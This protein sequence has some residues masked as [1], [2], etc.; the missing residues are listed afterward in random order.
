MTRLIGPANPFIRTEVDAA[1]GADLSDPA[2]SWDWTTLGD[3]Q[4]GEHTR[5]RVLNQTI[6]VAHGRRDESNVADP[7][8]IEVE[9]GNGDGALTPRNPA[10]SLYPGLVRGTP[11]RVMV[12]AGS[13]YLALTGATGS[14][15]TTPDAGSWN[16]G[17]NAAWAVQFRAPLRYPMLG[18]VY[19][20][21]GQFTVSG[22]QRSWVL[23][24]DAA[25]FGRLRF[26]SNGTAEGNATTSLALPSPDAGPLTFAAEFDGDNGAG[27]NTTTFYVCRGTITEL[28]ADPAGF[29]FGDPFVN[30][31]TV[32]L[33]NSTGLIGVGDVPGSGF[34]PYPG[35]IAA[36]Y[37]RAGTLTSGTVVA[38]TR[39]LPSQA[40]GTTSF[41]DQAATP[42]TWTVNSS[43]VITNRHPRFTGRVDKVTAKWEQVDG[44][45]PLMPTIA[46]AHV[47]ASGVLERLAQGDSIG[48]ALARLVSAPVNQSGVIAAWMFEDGRD[49]TQAAQLVSG[50][51]PMRIRG[52]FSFGGDTSY[53]AVLQQ[54]TIGS[55]ENAYMSAP[56]PQIP[57][58]V[59]VNWQ[60]TRFFRI[61]DP[62]VAP[63]TTQLMAVDT[64]G[65]VATWRI[66][67]N[68]T[69]IV[70]TGVDID[71]TPILLDTLA[72]D[73]TWFDTEA[74]VVLEVTDN[75]ANVDWAVTMLP[76]PFG[77]GFTVSGSLAGNTGVPR[78]FRNSCT[79]P[80]SGISLGPLI[81][82]TGK[83]IG[84][85]AP[86]DTAF[87]G[88]PAPQRVFRLCQ[89]QGIP[90]AVDGPYGTDWA[91]GV[92]AGAQTMGPQRP[93]KLVGLLE[94]CATVDFGALGEQRGSLGLAFR[95]GVSL[96]NQ[97]TRLSLARADRQAIDPFEEVDDDQRFVND[98]TA[99]RPEGS[100]FRIEDPRIAAGAEER[101][102]QT[103]EVNT[104]T[105]LGLED[106]AGWRYHL[107]TWEEPRFPQAWSDV[108]KD[109]A[110]VDDILGFG[111]GDR[112]DLADPPPGCPPVDQLAD[113]IVEELERFQWRVGL[114]GHP[115]R[116]WD[117]GIL[118]HDERSQPDT[119]GAELAS[120]FV[121]GTGT[122]M[123][124][125]TTEGDLW[126]TTAGDF[127]FHVEVAGVVLNVTN[128][129][130]ASSPQ[131]F[132]VTQA[133]VN[134]VAKTIPVGEPVRLRHGA[135]VAP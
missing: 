42:K 48:S 123:S 20:F 56:I 86:A 84:W 22:G 12:T 51:A 41:V 74:M 70:I 103:V 34:A 126:T 122:S 125:A 77:G 94:E 95:S 59:G 27:G 117:T 46:Y 52:D 135:I 2:E 101:Y 50:A 111:I 30:S 5:P 127:P 99:T 49:A 1:F 80:P 7:S 114:N 96:Q 98:V 32:T 71:D 76:I 130:G 73:P 118:E 14:N 100:S 53:P 120:Q 33:H 29:L 13:S 10:S 8:S 133:P 43:A 124:V 3:Y 113:G 6:A 9:L 112:F 102:E 66:A 104:A 132:T 88:E 18:L 91:Q 47:S 63:A 28:L 31:G 62:A 109:Q 37:V 121:A 79:G 35:T 24:A 19:E 21:F 23:S 40:A 45:N 97:P 64:N 87:V 55:G 58:V 90:V 38:D 54:L 60:V 105:D 39:N 15:V 4:D 93:E 131:T 92:A 78:M 67:I 69:Q 26:S 81:V 107:G 108:A 110:L 16:L 68:D 128:I 44:E 106:Q 115:A 57:Q 17:A 82:S 85:L 75:G 116:P 72:S 134:G 36:W 129:T 65:V 119:D 61:D 89:E 11:L 83:A 25:G